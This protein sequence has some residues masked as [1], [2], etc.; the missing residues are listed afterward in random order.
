[1]VPRGTGPSLSS[2][3]EKA[4]LMGQPAVPS[5]PGV[6]LQTQTSKLG[7]DNSPYNLFMKI[8]KGSSAEV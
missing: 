8:Q 6:L 2:G 3:G 4:L 7:A 1:M 5:S